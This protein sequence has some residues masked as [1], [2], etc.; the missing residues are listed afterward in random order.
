MNNAR[1]LKLEQLNSIQSSVILL[2]PHVL[3]LLLHI[4]M[5][6]VK[7]ASTLEMAYQSELQLFMLFETPVLITF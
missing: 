4:N 6:A 3:F 7:K 1:A 2:F 5:S